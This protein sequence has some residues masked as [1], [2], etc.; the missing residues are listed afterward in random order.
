[1]I[2]IRIDTDEIAAAIAKQLP[3]R[4]EAHWMTLAETAEHLRVSQRWLRARLFEIPHRRIDG[5]LIFR[6]DEIDN[7]TT[8]YNEGS[9]A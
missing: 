7:W 1:M 9:R 5:K 2:E 3:V 4:Q 8:R 6:S